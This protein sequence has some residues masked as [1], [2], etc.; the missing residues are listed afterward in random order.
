MLGRAIDRA[1]DL[2][3]R[4]RRPMAAVLGLRT[5]MRSIG[6]GVAVL[7]YIEELDDLAAG[8]ATEH[9]ARRTGLRHL[10]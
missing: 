4:R 10:G 7:V 1:L 9:V 2:T 8:L 5:P 3:R 6:Y